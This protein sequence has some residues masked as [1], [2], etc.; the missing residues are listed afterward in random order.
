MTSSAGIDATAGK[1]LTGDGFGHLAERIVTLV[2]KQDVVDLEGLRF[3]GNQK[4]GFFAIDISIIQDGLVGELPIPR[5][6]CMN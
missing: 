5:E 6:Q 2:H 4:H 3:A 1:R